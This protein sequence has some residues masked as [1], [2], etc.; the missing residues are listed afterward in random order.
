[1]YSE[2]IRKIASFIDKDDS[3]VDI[4]CDH[5]Y[6][7]AY[8]KINNLCKNVIASDINKNALNYAIN[9]F[10]NYNLNIKCIL[11][12]GFTNLK[13]YYDTAV[14][15]GMGS[16]TIL[17]ILNFNKLPNKLVLASNN[18]YYL[19]RKRLNEMNYKLLNE[20][21]VYEKEHYYVVMKYIKGKQSL[22]LKELKYGISNNKDYYK[23]L[24]NKNK[25]LIKKVPFK[26]KIE[27]LKEIIILKGLI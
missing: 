9:N 14:I 17:H 25:E 6:L 10:K 19:L 16:S 4:G 11:S 3:V 26:K 21:V 8:L 12:D 20:E 13:D 2:R 27:L 23:Y 24:L 15:A 7:C 5:G 18:D 1:M 22:S